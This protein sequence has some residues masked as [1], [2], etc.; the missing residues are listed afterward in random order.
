MDSSQTFLLHDD[1]TL[2]ALARHT[3]AH[4]HPPVPD[5]VDRLADAY[6]AAV[7]DGQL[8]IKFVERRCGHEDL[9]AWLLVTF[10]D[11][12]TYVVAWSQLTTNH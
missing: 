2:R 6:A 12:P 8:T 10:G 4:G 9:G 11:Q 5:V 3:L 7:A 1:A